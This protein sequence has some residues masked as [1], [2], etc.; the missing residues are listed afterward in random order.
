MGYALKKDGTIWTWGNQIQLGDNS[1]FK[2]V[3]YA[4]KMTLP[5]GINKVKMIQV[6]A[7]GGR[8]YTYYLLDQ[9]DTL[10][11]L[12]YNVSGQLGIPS[13]LFQK[14]WVVPEYPDGT[15]M[16]NIAWIS[17]NE[18]DGSNP[19]IGAINKNG[20]FYTAGSNSRYMIGRD[21]TPTGKIYFGI[22][23]GISSTD[24][25]LTCELG[26]H[27]T[28]VT[29]KGSNNYGYVG[30]RIAGSMG[31]GSN[32]DFEQQTFDFI[33]TPSVDIC[34]VTCNDPIIENN[35]PVCNGKEGIFKIRSTPNDIITFSL[36]NG[37]D[38]KVTIDLTGEF[39]I[40][41][42][43]ITKPQ[44]LVIKSFENNVCNKTVTIDSTIDITDKT[45]PEFDPFAPICFNKTYPNLPTTSTNGI[46]GT[47][48]PQINN[49]STTTYLFTPD[50]DECATTYSIEIPVINNTNITFENV[51]QTTVNVIV[52]NGTPTILYQ[53]LDENGNVIV[54]WQNSST[55]SNLKTGFYFVEV[56]TENTDCS[57]I[58]E[59]FFLNLNNVI[60]PNFDGINDQINLSFMK[61]FPNSRFELYNKF[62]T[63]VM[64]VDTSSN[65]QNYEK[66]NTDNYWYIL[67][68]QDG[69]TK[70]GWLLIKR[71]N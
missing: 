17:S 34:G 63:K 7:W 6:T 69:T 67:H 57:E 37:T 18:H 3:S 55:F 56:K 13:L 40:K 30:H 9:N 53:L 38:Q 47:W 35:S 39:E 15:L 24:I 50:D 45:V 43:N 2:D 65:H 48:D 12:G 49:Q 27:C 10:H 22:P 62:G 52:L 36:N 44:K 1:I 58:K 16:N 11:C 46:S 28:A 20:I 41:I 31:D 68:L 66:I 29:K 54:S 59:F 60:S 26:G 25:I 32:G 33:N 70:T 8:Y 5:N 19:T 51:N 14:T 64:Q 42:P 23:N 4:T 21:Y 61:R 71:R